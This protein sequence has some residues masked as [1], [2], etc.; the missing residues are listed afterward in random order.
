MFTFWIILH[1]VVKGNPAHLPGVV[2]F[3]IVKRG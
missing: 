1:L 3:G 2:N